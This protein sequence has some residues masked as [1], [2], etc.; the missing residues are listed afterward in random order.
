MS[1][2]IFKTAFIIS[3]FILNFN[4]LPIILKVKFIESVFFKLTSQ[5]LLLQ[6]ADL[7][8][9]IVFQKVE[10]NNTKYFDMCKNLTKQNP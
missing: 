4:T 8:P 3:F 2:V 6:V 5:S 1:I 9:W 10:K 7:F